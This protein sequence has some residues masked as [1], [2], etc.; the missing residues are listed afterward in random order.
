MTTHDRDREFKARGQIQERAPPRGQG[1]LID[2]PTTTTT[3]TTT[4]KPTIPVGT[5]EIP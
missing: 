4:T 1:T 2:A 3:T 5:K